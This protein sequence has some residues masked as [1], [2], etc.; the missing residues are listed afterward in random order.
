MGI[1]SDLSLGCHTQAL[2]CASTITSLKVSL[3]ELEENQLG[4]HL[5]AL[6]DER[7]KIEAFKREL[8]LCMQL[9]E[10]AI[11]KLKEQLEEVQPAPGTPQPLQLRCSTPE[12]FSSPNG[13]NMLVLKEFMPLKKRQCQSLRKEEVGNDLQG[14]QPVEQPRGIDIGRPALMAEAQLW[15]QQVATSAAHIEVCS[16]SLT[17]SK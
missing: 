2:S 1:S 11:A 12:K 9:L 17:S 4:G 7:Q 13:N 10:E 16:S 15:T 8:P 14:D 3:P 5:H 6:E